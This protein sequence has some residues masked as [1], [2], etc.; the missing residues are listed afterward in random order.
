MGAAVNIDFMAC[1]VEGMEM[2]TNKDVARVSVPLCGSAA[3]L[4]DKDSWKDHHW[5]RFIP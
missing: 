2:G 3:T 5:W 4:A 1:L